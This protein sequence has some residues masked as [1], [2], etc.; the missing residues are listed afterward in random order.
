MLG[1]GP[2]QD[3]QS[4][5]TAK[6][7]IESHF[8]VPELLAEDY[9]MPWPTTFN[10]AFE[11]PDG[12][13]FEALL[14]GFANVYVRETQACIQQLQQQLA[15]KIKELSSH[16]QRIGSISEHKKVHIQPILHLKGE[17]LTDVNILAAC[18]HVQN[19]TQSVHQV[20]T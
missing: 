19:Q 11:Q 7:T 13:F 20:V 17:L 2:L 14:P 16:K 18:M 1:R 6:V 3:L 5:G 15:E 9:I 8:N 10:V 4:A 12:I